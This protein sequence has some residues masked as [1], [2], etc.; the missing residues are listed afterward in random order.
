MTMK[1]RFA[2]H[3]CT[4]VYVYRALPFLDTTSDRWIMRRYQYLIIDEASQGFDLDIFIFLNSI[5]HPSQHYKAIWPRIYILGYPYEV[6]PNT[7]VQRPAPYFYTENVSF[8]DRMT[9]EYSQFLR[10]L[11]RIPTI[12]I[13]VQYLMVPDIFDLSN[14]GSHRNGHTRISPAKRGQ[15]THLGR[16]GT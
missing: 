14:I 8:L 13:V 1:P 7:R 12:Q 6:P 10:F 2:K 5:A 9:P 15:L 16:A 4:L 11:G 3:A